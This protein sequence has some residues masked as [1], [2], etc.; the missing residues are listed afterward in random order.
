M[1]VASDLSDYEGELELRSE[2]RITDRRSG[3]GAN[4]PATSESIDFPV[5]VP[6]AATTD[7][8][9]GSLCEITTTMERSSP[10]P[11]P[12]APDR[13]GSSTR[14]ASTTAAPT[15]SRQPQDN[16]LFAVQGLFVP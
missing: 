5:T 4:E 6:C 13:S 12:K 15:G 10:A 2:I 11:S 1:R 3:P 16:T 7:T 14:R 9:I 8:T